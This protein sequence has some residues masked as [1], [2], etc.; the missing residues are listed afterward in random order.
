[1]QG[2]YQTKKQFL[3]NEKKLEKVHYR[4]I[5]G[6]TIFGAFYHFLIQ[7]KTIGHDPRYSIYIFGLPTVVGMLILGIYRRQFLINRFTANKG[8]FLRGFVVFFY[9]LQGL[10]FSYISFGQAAKIAW[11]YCNY[12]TVQQN[13]KEVLICPIT[14]FYI[15]RGSQIDFKFSSRSEYFTTKYSMIKEYDNK[16]EEDFFIRVIAIKGLWNYYTVCEWTIERK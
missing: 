11:D 13:S 12:R 4:I 5:I 1:M 9:L 7:P 10:L 3:Q 14:R 6:L 8:L 15:G 16:R 2:K